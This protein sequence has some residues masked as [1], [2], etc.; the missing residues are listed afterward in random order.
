M[1][2]LVDRFKIWLRS[3]IYT[4]LWIGLP[5]SAVVSF[6][7]MFLTTHLVGVAHEESLKEALLAAAIVAIAWIGGI[8]QSTL[9]NDEKEEEE[10]GKL[11]EVERELPA[12]RVVRITVG[13]ICLLA[14]VALYFGKDVKEWITGEE[15]CVKSFIDVV[16]VVLAVVAAL[17]CCVWNLRIK[18]R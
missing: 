13:V 3:F 11:S 18:Q 12:V 1:M 17:A 14:L 15:S 2:A 10:R 16:R 9:D 7:V 4:R 5:L 6:V 8:L